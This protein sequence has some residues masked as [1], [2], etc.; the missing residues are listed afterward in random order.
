MIEVLITIVVCVIGLWG[1]TEVQSRLQMSEVESYQRSQALM[2]LDD[3][4]TRI[5]L[6]RINAASYVTGSANPLGAGITCSTST[7]S[8]AQRDAG[9]WCNL[10]QGVAETTSGSARV[11]AMLG[12]RGC[13]EN[14]GTNRYMITV[15]WQGMAPLTA[16]PSSVACGANAFDTSGTACVNDLCR[17]AITTVV[18]IG[19]LAS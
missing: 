13:V 15:A 16:P 9:E 14:I 1:L 7:G 4:S 5:D 10:L 19:N 18:R 2:L 12:A 3:M 6:N 8:L 11:G 17:R